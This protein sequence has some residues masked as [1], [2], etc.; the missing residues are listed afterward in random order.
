MLCVVGKCDERLCKYL[1]PIMSVAGVHKGKLRLW[2]QKHLQPII[3]SLGQLNRRKISLC[4]LKEKY[5]LNTAI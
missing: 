2:S 4:L 1:Q 5:M 3:S